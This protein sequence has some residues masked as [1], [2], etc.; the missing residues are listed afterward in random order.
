MIYTVTLNPAL[1][2]VI[3]VDHFEAGKINRNTKENLYYGGKGIN[4]SCILRELDIETTALGFIGGFTGQSLKEGMSQM[5]II[6]NFINVKEGMTRINVKM[7]S[8]NETEING[9]GPFITPEDF[10][11][12]LEI[13]K[14][15]KAGDTLVL[16]GSIPSCMASDTYEKILEVCDPAVHVVVDAE[17][18]LLLKILKYHPFLIKPNNIELAAMFDVELK[19]IDDIIFYAKKLQE[20]G[21]VN[22]VISMAGDGAILVDE[23]GEVYRRGVAKGTVVNSVGAGDSMVAGFMA[24]YIKTGDYAYALKLGTACGGAT[25]FHSALAT[26]EEIEEV[27]ATLD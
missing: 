10:N 23:K 25:A 9:M 20:M 13:I 14:T 19:N 21:A 27:L 4:V 7:K 22:V 1:D 12:F 2:Y 5:G 3:Q 18:D 15:L 11:A 6:T 17:K 8:D 24:G 16:A 26:R